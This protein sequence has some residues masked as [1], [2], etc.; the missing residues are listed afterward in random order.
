MNISSINPFNGQ[1][2]KEYATLSEE[3]VQTKIEQTHSAWVDWKKTSHEQRSALMNR[4]AE[5]FA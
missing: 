3:Q 4:L 5:I 1:Q 2:I